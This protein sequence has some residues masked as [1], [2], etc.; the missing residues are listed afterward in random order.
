MS[1][2]KLAA[3]A[4]E[5]SGKPSGVAARVEA[6]DLMRLLEERADLIEA[7]AAAV[8]FLT[9]GGG[10]R[11]REAAAGQCLAALA[12]ARDEATTETAAT[13]GRGE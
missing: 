11:V 12:F 1:P 8:E 2:G 13:K 9:G 6:V 7:C 10:I 5:C 3:L 4:S